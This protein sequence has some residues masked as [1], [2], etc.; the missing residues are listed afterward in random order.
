ML[1][2][3]ILHNTFPLDIYNKIKSYLTEYDLMTPSC[4]AIISKAKEE[5]LS[6][7]RK[8]RIEEIYTT[9][10]RKHN[11]IHLRKCYFIKYTDIEFEGKTFTIM[12]GLIKILYICKECNLIKPYNEYA[13]DYYCKN[14]DFSEIH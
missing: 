13:D 12:D 6:I 4:L 11:I 14:C 5:Y 3:Y 1:N 8:M 10:D 2:L 7:I 9:L